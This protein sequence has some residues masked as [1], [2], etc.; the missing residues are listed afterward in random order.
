MENNKEKYPYIGIFK[1]TPAPI[2]YTLGYVDKTTAELLDEWREGVKLTDYNTIDSTKINNDSYIHKYLTEETKEF[3][4]SVA[5][6]KMTDK[7]G[8]KIYCINDLEF[9]IIKNER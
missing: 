3:I 8:E 4:E 9:N 2:E 7:L 1:T 6:V 5:N